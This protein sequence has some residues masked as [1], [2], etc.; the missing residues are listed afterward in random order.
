VAPN[1]RANRLKGFAT[2][3]FGRLFDQGYLAAISPTVRRLALEMP[4]RQARRWQR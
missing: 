3:W 1:L 2:P 4:A